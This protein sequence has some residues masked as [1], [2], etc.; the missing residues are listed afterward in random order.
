MN[1]V[2]ISRYLISLFI[3]KVEAR[4]AFNDR[5]PDPRGKRSA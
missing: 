4:G 2:N 5:L 3:L 1:I